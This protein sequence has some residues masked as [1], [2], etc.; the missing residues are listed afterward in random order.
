MATSKEV[1]ELAK[2]AGVYV[3]TRSP[4]DGVTRYL[5]ASVPG[6]YSTWSPFDTLAVHLGARAALQFLLGVQVGRHLEREQKSET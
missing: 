3:D 5:F 2:A 4:G 6:G 1:R